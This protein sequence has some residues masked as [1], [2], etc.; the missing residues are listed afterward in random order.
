MET[1]FIFLAAGAYTIFALY[2]LELAIIGLSAFFP[3]YLIKG[4]VVGIPV[5]LIE[6]LIYGSTLAYFLLWIKDFFVPKG[7]FAA[8]F[9]SMQK[10]L[11]PHESFLHRYRYLMVGVGLLLLAAF[12]SLFVTPKELILPDGQV[13]PGMRV[14]LGILKGWIIAPV[15]YLFL[16]L[17]VIRTSRQGLKVVNA[18]TLSAV[19]LGLLALFQVITQ[20]YITPDMRASGP[21][22]NANYLAL[23][24][25]P[26]L[27]YSCVRV[28]EALAEKKL[29]SYTS[30][31]FVGGLVLFLALLTSKSYAGILAFFIG[32]LFYFGLEYSRGRSQR[33]FPWKVLL[34]IGGV[35][36]VV[37]VAVFALDPSK[38]QAMFQ[39]A[40]RNSS[41]VRIQ[42]YTIAWGLIGDHWLMGIGMGQFP[43]LYQI[44]AVK[45]L[46][47]EPFEWNMLHPHNIFLATWLNLGLLGV[48]ALIVLLGSCL[49]KV[50]DHVKT[51]AGE[52]MLSVG[53]IR[54]LMFSLLLIIIVH[55]FFDTP[56]FKND[57]A[58]LFW[59]IVGILTAVN[60]DR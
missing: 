38:W 5:T 45:I 35:L 12:L 53:K 44:E 30:L 28:R 57:L 3:L 50:W 31:F 40:E 54:V 8:L 29:T 58:L 19:V 32:G 42:V 27:L 13:F 37:L 47:K 52:K 18:Y 23:Y 7:R 24:I 15:L 1:F 56:F 25:V 33:G 59:M 4:D 17:A 39:F 41:S 9:S 2:R 60:R 43:A 10:S 55:G 48:G 16:L 20:N 22:E 21:F 11:V 49:E 36:A 51:F 14:A 34:V 6:L 26:A 46:G